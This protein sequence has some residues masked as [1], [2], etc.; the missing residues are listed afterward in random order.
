MGPK[1]LQSLR[2]DTNHSEIEL[3]QLGRED[4]GNSGWSKVGLPLTKKHRSIERVS[5]SARCHIGILSRSRKGDKGV[6]AEESSG[7]LPGKGASLW[8]SG[9]LVSKIQKVASWVTGP[10]LE[11]PVH[12]RWMLGV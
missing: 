11:L 3:L 6:E 4:E 1:Y 7:S 8:K 2:K 10:V 5:R 12:S 9:N